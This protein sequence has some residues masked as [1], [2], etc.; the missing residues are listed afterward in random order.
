MKL[1]E[2]LNEKTGKFEL[3]AN[4]KPAM[5]VPHGGACCTNCEYFAGKGRCNNKYFI[6]Y[7]GGSSIIPGKPSEFCSDWYEP[8]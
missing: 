3:P 4:H 7:Q 6:E 2:L 1:K 5:K 8:K